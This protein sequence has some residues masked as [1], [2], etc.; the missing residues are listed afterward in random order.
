MKNCIVQSP[1]AL[2]LIFFKG[3]LFFG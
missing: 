1:L 2:N 3:Q